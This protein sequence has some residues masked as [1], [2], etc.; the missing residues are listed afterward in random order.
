MRAM[1]LGMNAHLEV[2]QVQDLG[3]RWAVR[4][5]LQARLLLVS[6]LDL[7]FEDGFRVDSAEA[8][9]KCRACR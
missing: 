5:P 1:A 8:V 3:E 4:H 6:N 2:V 9:R 7:D